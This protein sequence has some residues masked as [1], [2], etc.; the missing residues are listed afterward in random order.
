ME[1]P[2]IDAD[3]LKT[4]LKEILETPSPTGY[5]REAISCV[6]RTIE[7]FLPQPARVIRKGGL[8]AM[9]PGKE[10]SSARAVTAH[11]DTLGAMVKDIKPNGRLHMSKLGGY[12]WN[13]V[14][15]EGCWVQT[16]DKGRIRGSILI[17][18]ASVHVYGDKVEKTSREDATMEVRLDAITTSQAETKSLGVD[19]G[20]FV[21]FDPRV[22][23]TNGFVRSRHLDDKSGVA[24]IAAALKAI[25]DAGLTPSHNSYFF[26]SNYEEAGHGGAA[27][28][29]KEIDELLVVDMAAVGEGQ[30]SDEF[31]TT[32]C[33]KDGDGAYHYD[34][35]ER[36]K[37]LAK[38]HQI[39][40]KL[41]IYP[42]YRSDGGALLRAGAD[43]AVAL[44]GPGVDAS[45]NYERTHMDGLIA[46]TRWILAYLLT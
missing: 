31:H 32:L 3:F 2:R 34:L 11:T 26:I 25:S 27:G 7:P 37:D 28:L 19:V 15:G 4:F 30:N 23:I 24:C 35:M 8:L 5:S 36:L 43:V 13:T 16:H 40:Y 29:P 17:E 39:D 45:H 44:I 46:T 12:A 38:Q 20:D 21:F 18:K 1:L 41:D 42:Y 33:V 14:E 10:T 9:L 6:Q 22:E